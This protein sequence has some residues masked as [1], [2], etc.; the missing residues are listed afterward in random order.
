[1]VSIQHLEGTKSKGFC[2]TDSNRVALLAVGNERIDIHLQ[3]NISNT[4]NVGET[5]GNGGV[6]IDKVDVTYGR[7]MG[8]SLGGGFNQDF[9]P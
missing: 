9:V 3:D 8:R 4:V 6:V 7:L 5:G 2:T 1:M